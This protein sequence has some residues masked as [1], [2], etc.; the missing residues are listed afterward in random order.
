MTTSKEN[1]AF[2]GVATAEKA[3]KK[4]KSLN[5]GEESQNSSQALDISSFEYSISLLCQALRINDAITRIS[6]M[7]AAFGL[8]KEKIE[9]TKEKIETI[10]SDDQSLT[11]GLAVAYC[12]LA[13]AYTIMNMEQEAI[14]ACQTSMSFAKESKDALKRGNSFSRKSIIRFRLVLGL[15]LVALMLQFDSQLLVW[16]HLKRKVNE[17]GKKLKVEKMIAGQNPILFI[18]I[19]A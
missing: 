12:A 16:L 17:V 5:E 14:N 7:K 3:W 15:V 18:A 10:S 13:R 6:E 11:E 19:T 2:G 1:I 8:P 4:Y 9:T